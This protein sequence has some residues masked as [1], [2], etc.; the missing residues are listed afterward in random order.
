MRVVEVSEYGDPSVMRITQRPRPTPTGNEVRIDVARAG[1]N[2]ADIEKRRGNYPDG[3]TPPYVPGIE[4]SGTIDATGDDVDR[5]IGEEVTAIIEGGGYAEYAVTTVDRLIEIPVG[6]D[7]AT[8]VALP[9]QFLTAH[10]TLFEWGSL[11]LGERV[12]VHAAA[13]GVGTAAVQLAHQAGATV[14]GTASTVEKL[15]VASKLGVTHPIDYTTADVAAVIDDI[16]DGEGVDLVLDGVGGD[17]FYASVD[18]LADCGRIVVYGMASGNIPTVATPRLFFENQSL[19]GYHLG[20]A[21]EHAPDRVHTGI[22][23]LTD[24]LETEEYTVEIDREIPLTEVMDAH[25]AL[26]SRDT[27][28]KTVLVP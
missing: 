19:L 1:V 20:H 24:R 22:R 16:T 3:P 11:E 10:N 4:V 8:A 13:G 28:G 6:M 26:A 18:A 2:F 15:S 27:I 5:Q 7:L 23:T 12:L 21:I 25:K 9:V 14:F 17:A